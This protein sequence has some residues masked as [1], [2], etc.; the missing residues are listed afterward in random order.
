MNKYY[1]IVS[2]QLLFT[3]AIYA[4]IGIN[5]EDPK[6]T[7]DITGKKG[8]ADIDGVLFPRLTLAE[9]TAK[10]DGLYGA[11]QNGVLIFI[12]DVT[13]GDVLSQRTNIDESGYYYFDSPSNVWIKMDNTTSWKAALTTWPAYP[14]ARYIYQNGSLG[15]GDYS[16]KAATEKLDV[17]GN[18]RLRNIRDGRG[19]NNYPNTI[20]AN[21][22][23][24]LAA[25]RGSY[26]IWRAARTNAEAVMT[27]DDEIV[28]ILSSSV[29]TITLPANPV[30]GRVITIR[31]DSAS[32][33]VYNVVT[34][35]V[36]WTGYLPIKYIPNHLQIVAADYITR[37]K[38]GT[39]VKLQW[40]G[41]PG[42][43]GPAGGGGLDWIQIEG[44]LQ[45]TP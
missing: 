21:S 18:V 36:T 8:V 20:V 38:A 15:I 22:E 7:L 29:T 1:V 26:A 16:T 43:Y 44:D 12:T 14:T 17:D 2:L 31:I 5:I 19:R 4:Q 39:T 35:N 40:T 33:G 27:D 11:D 32:D 30:L 6:A 24:T 41:P 37:I 28:N 42:L 25:F 10:G 34:P 13:G 9:L 45:V 23:G 3:G